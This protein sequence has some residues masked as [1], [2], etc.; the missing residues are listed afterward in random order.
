VS[1]LSPLQRTQIPDLQ[2]YRTSDKPYYRLGHGVSLGFFAFGLLCMTLEWRFYVR[3]NKA[4]E[5][6]TAED[7]AMMDEAGVTGDRHYSF[8]YEW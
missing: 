5:R 3:R 2:I 6:M 4:K 7:K 8:K 1:A